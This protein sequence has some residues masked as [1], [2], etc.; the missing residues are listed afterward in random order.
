MDSNH[1]DEPFQTRSVRRGAY[2]IHARDYPGSG[3]RSCY[4]MGSPTT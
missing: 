3:Q 2:R 4:C 1:R